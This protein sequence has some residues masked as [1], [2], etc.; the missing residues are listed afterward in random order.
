MK[1]S[2][3]ISVS[4]KLFSSSPNF[5]ERFWAKLVYLVSM[6]GGTYPERRKGLGVKLT[7]HF[8]LVSSLKLCGTLP[9]HLRTVVNT[10]VRISNALETYFCYIKYAVILHYIFVTVD[11]LNDKTYYKNR[12]QN[13]SITT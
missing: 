10:F 3:L 8:H 9:T 5:S 6:S 7:T 13:F 1:E 11:T 4:S 12:V 2:G